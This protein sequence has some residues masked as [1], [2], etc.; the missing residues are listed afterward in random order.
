VV[1]PDY[2]LAPQTRLPEILKDV[3][4]LFHWVRTELP[5]K[6]PAGVAVDVSRVASSGSS[7]GLLL[8]KIHT[9]FLL[10]AD[11]SLNAGRGPH[12]K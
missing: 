6:L 3:R 9:I 12:H 11:V 10:L 8:R 7:A 4:D 5:S 2:R 1:S